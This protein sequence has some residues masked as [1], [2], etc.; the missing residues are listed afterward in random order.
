M[1]SYMKLASGLLLTGV[2]IAALERMLA[3]GMAQAGVHL[4]A[5]TGWAV[6]GL[7]ILPLA[8]IAAGVLVYI[9]GAVLGLK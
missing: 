5:G 9:G 6:T 1:K 4:P 2:G 7:A 3:G 8:L